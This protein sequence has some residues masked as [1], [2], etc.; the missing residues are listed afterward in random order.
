MIHSAIHIGIVTIHKY[1]IHQNLG[2]IQ[3]TTAVT[4]IINCTQ[5]YINIWYQLCRVNSMMMLRVR[6]GLLLLALNSHTSPDTIDD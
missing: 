6:Y 5:H 4:T 2:T 1:N 3:Y